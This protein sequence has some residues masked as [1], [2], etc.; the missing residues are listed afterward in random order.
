V[1]GALYFSEEEARDPEFLGYW[2]Y[3]Y[4]GLDCFISPDSMPQGVSAD[5]HC[6]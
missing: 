2:L 3:Q 5:E 4:F 6:D 1:T